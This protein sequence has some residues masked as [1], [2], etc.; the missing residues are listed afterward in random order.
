M[1][2]DS[3]ARRTIIGTSWMVVWRMLTRVL[4]LASTLILARL[5]VPADFGIVAMAGLF[6][7]IVE[8]LSQVGLASALIRHPTRDRSLFDTAWTLQVVRALLVAG[9]LAASAPLAAWWFDEPRL[10]TVVLVMATVSAITGFDN[11]ALIEFQR[12][13]RFD[14]YF[15]VLAAPR[16][17]QVVVTISAALLLQSYWALILGII[18]G[19]LSTSAMSYRMHPYRPGFRLDGWREFAHF[20]FWTWAASLAGLVRGRSDWFI[21]GPMFGPAGLGLYMLADE[22]AILPVTELIGPAATALFAGFSEAQRR[23]GTSHLAIRVATTLLLFSAPVTIA[24]S[25]SA[26]HVVAALLGAKWAAAEPLIAILA[27]QCLFIPFS[28]ICSQFLIV[29]GRVELNFYGTLIAAVI[30]LVA[31]LLA[32]AFSRDLNTI[33]LVITVVVAAEA[34]IYIAM[35]RMAGETGLRAN[36]GGLLRIALAG[37]V[38]VAVLLLTGLGWQTGL[39]PPLLALLLAAEVGTAAVGCFAIVDLT[40]WQLAGRPDG[41]E[42]Q[43]LGALGQFIRLRRP[44]VQQG[45]P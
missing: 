5:L 19:R 6:G 45:I 27:W 34:T 39:R 22:T 9:M 23:G 13:M 33:A 21:L 24:V 25:A 26:P 40:L 31:T 20:S 37:A 3:L 11:I 41:P 32:V 28:A 29:R 30:K 7:T 4:G 36:L 17:L 8:G 43:L 35:L 2:E 1:A 38:T 42:R 10:V 12:D 44:K 15:V 14:R 18:A 16:L